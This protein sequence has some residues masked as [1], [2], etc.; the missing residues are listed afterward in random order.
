MEKTFIMIK[1]WSVKDAKEILIE[2]D[3]YG[4]RTRHTSVETVPRE[5]IQSHYAQHRGKPFFDYMTESFVGKPVEIAVYEGRNVI[6]EMIEII[7]VTDPAKA[8]PNSIRARY[9]TDSLEKALREGRPLQNVIHRSD[10][11]SEALREIA[12][13]QEYF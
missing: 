10:S 4:I 2:L 9:S 8:D 5:V 1:P 6:A 11:L 12:V 3:D 13:W 7:G